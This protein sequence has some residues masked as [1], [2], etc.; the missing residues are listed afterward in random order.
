LRARHVVSCLFALAPAAP[1]AAGGGRATREAAVIA[2]AP[3]GG[4]RREDIEPLLELL[5]ERFGREAVLAAP[6]PLP[7]EAWD[8]ARGQHLTTPILAALA[9]AREPGWERLLG[10]A[11]VDLHAPPLNFVF[12]EADAARRVAL[13]S[14]ARLRPREGEPGG[15]ELLRLRAATEAVHELG[16]AYG[17]DHCPDPRCVMWFSDTLAESDRKGTRFCPAH[18]R[19]LPRALGR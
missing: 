3:V 17:L 14:L 18:A 13:F 6:V 11:D 15:L 2:V 12:G 4:A 9:R 16:H 10:V 19:E 8:P 7:G 5:R 1:F